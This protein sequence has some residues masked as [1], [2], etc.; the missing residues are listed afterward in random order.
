[1]AVKLRW[2]QGWIRAHNVFH[3]NLTKP[4]LARSE[5]HQGRRAT[6]PPLPVKFFEGEP[7]YLREALLGHEVAKQ[8]RMHIYCFLVKWQGYTKEYNQKKN[9]NWA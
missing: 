6:Q 3:V 9:Y 5:E 4:Y 1:M 8:G 2:S 7:D